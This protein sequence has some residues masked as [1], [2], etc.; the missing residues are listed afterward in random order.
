MESLS[1]WQKLKANKMPRVGFRTEWTELSARAAS[2]FAAVFM[3][4]VLVS[5]ETKNPATFSGA[6]LKKTGFRLFS[7]AL[8]ASRPYQGGVHVLNNKCGYEGMRKNGNRGGT[9]AKSAGCFQRHSVAHQHGARNLP[10]NKDMSNGGN[11]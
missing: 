10:R 11:A 2:V 7:F 3:I 8:P 6:G 9:V 5:R 4:K 1:K